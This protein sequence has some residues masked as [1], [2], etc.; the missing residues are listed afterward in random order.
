MNTE[1]SPVQRF[2][3]CVAIS[4]NHLIVSNLPEAQAGR[5]GLWGVISSGRMGSSFRARRKTIRPS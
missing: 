5:Y 4:D 2:H 1:P 3:G